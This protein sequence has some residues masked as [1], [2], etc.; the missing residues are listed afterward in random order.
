MKVVYTFFL[1]LLL[2]GCTQSKGLIGLVSVDHSGSDT[3]VNYTYKNISE[4]TIHVV[5]GAK[6]S[7][8]ENNKVL[9][10]G[11]VPIKDYIDLAEGEEYKDSKVFKG[12]QPGAYTIQVK[13][14]E[15]TVSAD[16]T[17]K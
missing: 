14:S 13:W 12:L 11:S 5:G 7:L 8:L 6:Y 10:E 2:V 4:K 15:T 16:F 3:T 1:A 9:E 17:V